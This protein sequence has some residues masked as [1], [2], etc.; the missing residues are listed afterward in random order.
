MSVI[1][2]YDDFM[3]RMDTLLDAPKTKEKDSIAEFIERFKF[4]DREALEH[5]FL[6]GGCYYFA[7]LL[8][9]LYPGGAIYYHSV[10]NHFC[11]GIFDKTG[12][13]NYYDISGKLDETYIMKSIQCHEMM[14]WEDYKQIEPLDAAR[15]VDY[16]I[17][18]TKGQ[19]R[20]DSYDE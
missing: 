13:R 4:Q 15:V 6:N 18:R 9:N 3:K 12:V 10:D 20:K 1:S 16:C 11:Y 19:K 5:Y 7:I 17:Y 14:S 2:G 8:S